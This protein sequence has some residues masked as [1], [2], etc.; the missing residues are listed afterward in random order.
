[1]DA[2]RHEEIRLIEN[3]STGLNA[4]PLDQIVKSGDFKK[5]FVIG[6][7]HFPYASWNIID[8]CIEIIKDFRPDFVIQ[9]GDLYDMF[10]QSKFPK[11]KFVNP[12]D[13]FDQGRTE[14]EEMWY[15][16]NK[17][18]KS[19]KK[20]QLLGNHDARPYLRMAEKSPELAPF[21]NLD[22]P[23]EF[24]NVETFLDPTEEVIIG[25][26]VFQHGYRLK[27]GDQL[28]FNL[29]HTV[30]GHTHRGGTWFRTIRQNL[31]WELNAGYVANPFHDALKY[32]PQRWINWTWGCGL[33][34]RHGPRFIPLEYKK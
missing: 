29:I 25:G 19:A 4:I 9:V 14:A 8:Q 16:V 27:L 10:A 7:C 31:I 17:A 26:V 1:M 13:E 23:F 28:N 2:A 32:T 5:I 11:M 18:Y 6:D 3:K 15:K 30:G 33:I 22:K 34:D 12:K 20:I 21:I 24:D